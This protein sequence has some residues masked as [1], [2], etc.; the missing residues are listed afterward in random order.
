MTLEEGVT[1]V[2]GGISGLLEIA[3][4]TWN[5]LSIMSLIKAGI[6]ISII[7]WFVARMINRHASE[8]AIQNENYAELAGDMEDK[9]FESSFG[10]TYGQGQ[11]TLTGGESG[12][13]WWD[14]NAEH[15][16]R[17]E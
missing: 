13:G 11:T 9:Q 5:G 14:E 7:G 16:T 3:I 4:P 2:Q 10:Q 8:T 15:V 12:E 17:Y 1:L 6:Y